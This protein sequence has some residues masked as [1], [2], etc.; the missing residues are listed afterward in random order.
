MKRLLLV[1]ALLFSYFTS[2][3]QY[4]E[5]VITFDV[6]LSGDMAEQFK[7]M[8]PN[9]YIWKFKDGK[10]VMEMNGGM[11]AALMGNKIVY[12]GEKVYFINDAQKTAYEAKDEDK[13][14]TPEPEIKVT[15]LG[16]YETIAGYKCKKY[17]VTVTSERGTQTTWLWATDKIKI[18]PPKNPKVGQGFIFKGVEGFPLKTMT[19]MSEVGVVVTTIAKSVE[20]K[21]LPD[22]EFEVPNG[23]SVKPFSTLLEQMGGTGGNH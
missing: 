8:M 18:K 9:T 23:Y 10:F 5:G 7:P 22:S 21:S 1:V 15:D 2:Y 4:F 6:K 3:G 20:K 12:T 16:K 13:E 14:N 17:K 19:E 11:M